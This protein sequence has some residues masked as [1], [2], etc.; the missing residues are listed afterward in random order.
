MAKR[1]P[2][3]TGLG[4]TC[5]TILRARIREHPERTQDMISD[6]ELDS[7]S[8]ERLTEVAKMLGLKIPT[9]QEIGFHEMAK[10][11]GVSRHY[12]VRVVNHM[13]R[14]SGL[15]GPGLMRLPETSFMPLVVAIDLCA[16]ANEKERM[17]IARRTRV[18]AQ[19]VFPLEDVTPATTE[20]VAEG[21]H[22]P[23]YAVIDMHPTSILDTD[24]MALISDQ[25]VLD[26]T[27]FALA[28]MRNLAHGSSIRI[29]LQSNGRDT[30]IEQSK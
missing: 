30:V 27:N 28:T 15:G 12:V 26:A 10:N 29:V 3:G 16:Q 7:G 20:A 4:T 17:K 6:R 24:G 21:V 5:R 8:V 25:V 23:S 19:L 13:A 14:V 9:K 22:E 11:A 1:A 18:S 2:N